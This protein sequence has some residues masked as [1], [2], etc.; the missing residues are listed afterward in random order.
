MLKNAMLNA[1]ST[2][3]PW[4]PYTGGQPSPSPDYP[5]DIE[6]VGDDGNLSVIVKNPNNEQMQSVPFS[7]PNGLPGIPVASGGNYTD[8]DGRQ[9]VCDEIDFA[10]GVYVQRIA[11]KLL[12]SIGKYAVVSTVISSKKRIRIMDIPENTVLPAKTA[13]TIGA[14][15]TDFLFAASANKT[16]K[17]NEGISVEIKGAISFYI[18]SIQTVKQAQEYFKDNPMTISYALATPIETPLTSDQLT[19]YKQLHTYKGTT[20]ID[21]DAGAYMSVRYEKMK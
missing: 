10:R 1:G 14:V 4:E 13:D 8:A 2:R 7:T 19:A 11:K 16:Y 21:N 17:C 3:Y 18:E 15:M 20:I 9:W 12:T 5:Q 6:S